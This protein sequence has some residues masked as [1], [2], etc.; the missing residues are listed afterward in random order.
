VLEA[1]VEF[2]PDDQSL[3]LGFSPRQGALREP[4]VGDPVESRGLS[5]RDVPGGHDAIASVLENVTRALE[6]GQRALDGEATLALAQTRVQKTWSPELL[7]RILRSDPVLCISPAHVTSLRRWQADG[8]TLDGEPLFPG[9]PPRSRARF[10][11]LLQ[12]G[13]LE[14]EAL[15][16]RLTRELRRLDGAGDTDD[17]GAL[18]MARQL[19]D[20]SARWLER[21]AAEPPE[22]RPSMQAAIQILLE[23]FAID[24]DD[25]DA[26]S[27]DRD[28]LLAARAVLAAVLGGVGLDGFEMPQ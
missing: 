18:S 20:R 4:S 17:L 8:R 15:G 1:R 10:E 22:T 6:T 11:Q 19:A 7:H 27:L 12:Q 3:V 5:A 23:A 21:A 24:E 9:I 2:D 26:P 16:E 25:V 28:A 14:P 13:P